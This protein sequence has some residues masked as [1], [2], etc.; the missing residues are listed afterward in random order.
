MFSTW[1][2]KKNQI[3]SYLENKVNE[4]AKTK[5]TPIN[6]IDEH[7]FR[8]EGLKRWTETATSERSKKK[9]DRLFSLSPNQII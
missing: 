4:P 5:T 8:M 6:T 3:V 9:N 1:N 2:F 7:I